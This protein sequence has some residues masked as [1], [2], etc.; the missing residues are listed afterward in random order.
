MDVVLPLVFGLLVS[1]GVLGSGPEESP[2]D[3]PNDEDNGKE[4]QDEGAFAHKIPPV[5]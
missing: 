2:A 1:G 3:C 5:K 4:K